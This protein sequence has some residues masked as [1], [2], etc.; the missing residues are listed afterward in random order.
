MAKEPPPAPSQES[1]RDKWGSYLTGNAAQRKIIRTFSDLGNAA[2]KGKLAFIPYGFLGKGG[3]GKPFFAIKNSFPPQSSH[4]A[5]RNRFF[6]HPAAFHMKPY[7]LYMLY[8]FNCFC[9]NIPICP[10]DALLSSNP[11]AWNTWHMPSQRISCAS[12][13]SRCMAFSSSSESLS[14]ISLVP[15]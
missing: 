3:G 11:N 7:N 15:Q 9:R 10:M 4:S 13:P 1:H 8:L 2:D 6:L 14:R 12:T 5:A